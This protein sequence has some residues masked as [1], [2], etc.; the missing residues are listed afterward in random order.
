M[1]WNEISLHELSCHTNQKV[2]HIWTYNRL[3][4]EINKLATTY[5]YIPQNGLSFIGLTFLIEHVV[6]MSS[7]EKKY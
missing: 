3:I 7:V 2:S 4:V 6:F 1:F 5:C